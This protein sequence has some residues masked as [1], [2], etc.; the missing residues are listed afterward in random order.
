[1]T[2]RKPYFLLSKEAFSHFFKLN[3]QQACVVALR[4]VDEVEKAEDIV[5][6]VF[7]DLWEKGKYYQ[8][9][10]DG[11]S[12]LFSSVR[13]RCINFIQREKQNT[14]PIN[15]EVMN[16]SESV[17]LTDDE[18]LSIRIARI[19]EKMPPRCQQIF[20]LAYISDYSYQEIADELQV[21]KNTVKTQ[22]G[23]AYRL[24]REELK[25]YMMNLLGVF[26]N[27]CRK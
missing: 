1:M 5:Q 25:Q 27:L 6:D 22:M 24:L 11:R 3:Y 18:Q 19:I 4:Y 8:I 15:D 16:Q 12:Y 20:R 13:N 26:L 17:K 10:G 2:T 14:L 21:S 23:I 9:E 7:K